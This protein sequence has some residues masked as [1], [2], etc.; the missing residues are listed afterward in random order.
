VLVVVVKREGAVV[1]VVCWHRSLLGLGG[2][3]LVVDH[4]HDEA[5]LRED[6]YR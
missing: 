1:L 6:Y 2:D 3:R 5:T 4:A